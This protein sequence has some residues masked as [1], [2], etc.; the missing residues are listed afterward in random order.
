MCCLNK[1]LTAGG[2]RWKYLY[3]QTKKDGTM[4]QGAISLG[5]ITEEYALK[6]LKEQNSKTLKERHINEHR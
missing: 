6:M 5:L 4:I 3:D 2:Y 1:R